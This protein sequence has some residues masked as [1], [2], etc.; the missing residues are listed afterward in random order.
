MTTLLQHQFAQVRD[1]ILAWLKN[2]DAPSSS[3]DA[4]FKT[5][6]NQLTELVTQIQ[7]NPDDLETQDLKIKLQEFYQEIQDYHRHIQNKM[8]DLS[9]ETTQEELYHQACRAYLKK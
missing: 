8:A 5:L 3:D 6:E 1:D 4:H 7:S 2:A 9:T